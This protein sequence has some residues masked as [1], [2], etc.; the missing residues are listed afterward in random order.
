MSVLGV[1]CG[2]AVAPAWLLLFAYEAVMLVRG[3]G[4]PTAGPVAGVRNGSGS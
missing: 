3:L 1:I 2:L 4:E